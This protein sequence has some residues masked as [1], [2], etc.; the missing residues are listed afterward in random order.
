M[1]AALDVP[2]ARMRD[3]GPRPV[4]LRQACAVFLGNGLEFYDFFAYSYFAVYIGRT[5]FPSTDPATSLLASLA[6]FGVGFLTRPIGAI[7]IGAMGDR[8]GRKPAMLFSFS[9]MG[10]ALIG[11]ALTPSYAQIG[12]AAPV[13][14]VL[15]RLLQGFAVGGELGP[16][17]AFMAESAPLH[18]RGLYLSMQYVTQ[19]V[20][21]LIAGLLGVA[22]ASVLNDQQLQ[23]WGW[24]AALL[25]GAAI[26]PFGL[27]VRRTL[28][29]TL[30]RSHAEQPRQRLSAGL[31]A[32]RRIVVLGVA[33]IAS[34]T[35]SYYSASYMTTYA[36]T[37]LQ[38][39]AAIAFGLTVV[40]GSVSVV[41]ELITGWLSDKRGTQAGDDRRL[42]SRDR[43]D[44]SRL[45]DHRP[46]P[47]CMGVVRRR[48]R[49][50][51]LLRDGRD[52]GFH[53]HRRIST[54]ECAFRRSRHHLRLFVCDFRRL[55]AVH[56]RIAYPRYRQSAHARTVLGSR[57]DRGPL[58]HADVARIR[59]DQDRR[60]RLAAL[61]TT[62]RSV[63]GPGPCHCRCR[64]DAP[65]PLRRRA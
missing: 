48:S 65:C 33:I 63:R 64:A 42:R 9:L 8:H 55:G 35:I 19:D 34:G 61:G 46:I 7:V 5:F 28:P 27:I 38:M 60:N 53:H 57:H 12:I 37:T 30:T 29:E 21:A 6:T 17:T 49:D 39:P 51:R 3:A 40:N 36:L 20:A 14:V 47:Q 50:G 45:L 1:V 58:R 25:V 16:A 43:L 62:T 4:A 56:H 59:A 32:N 41:F 18:R 15:F 13:L 26:V 2:A 23:D 54:C 11:L 10:I 24:R 22:L 44:L 52:T 31:K